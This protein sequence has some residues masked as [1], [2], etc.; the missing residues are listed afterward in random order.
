MA[1]NPEAERTASKAG[2]R[3]RSAAWFGAGG[4]LGF[5]HRSW[6]KGEGLPDDVFDGRPV[7]GIANSWSELTPC[8]I[9]LRRLAEA[10][11][12]GVW[13]A[14]G[15]P[16]EFPTISLG[17][18]LMRP[19]TM[20]FRNLMAMDVEESIRANP[21]D[22]VVL[23]ASCD[24]TVPGQLMGAA[25]VDLPTIMVT[26]GP[27]LSGNFQG[28][29]IGSGTHVWKYSE[30]VRAGEMT[31]EE[32]LAAEICMS[33]SDGHCMTMGTAS[34]LASMSEALGIQ[35]AG[36]AAV[37]AV[38]ARRTVFAHQAGRRIV[39]MVEEDLRPSH[40]LTREAFENAIRVNAAIGGSTNFVVHLLALAGRV[41]VPL[42][43]EDFDDLAKDIP[44]LVN[45]MPSGTYL[46]EDFFHAGG[47]PALMKELGDLLH[48]D[49]RTVTGRTVTENVA[50]AR[51]WNRE[52][53]ATLDEPIQPSGSGTAV[54]RGNL[55]P[56]G[57]IIKQSA[58]SQ[59][60]MKHRGPAVV[61]DSI[62]EYETWAEDADLDVDE[63][64]VIVVRNAGPKGYPGMP[65]I[66]NVALPR[67][68]LAQGITD[69]VRISDARMSGTSYGTVVLHVAPEAAAGGPL[70]LVRTGD[71][72]ELD[73]PA[74][75]LRIDVSDEELSRRREAWRP[76]PPSADRGYVRLYLDHVMQADRGADLDFLTGGSGDAVPRRPF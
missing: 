33:R 6:V 36:S 2:T 75:S 53:I 57:A 71:R 62:E 41:G 30:A 24:K 60:L 61:F 66:A 1:G 34:T 4:K 18:T 37:P 39:G 67:K 7:I 19:S 51:C 25:S 44:L 48:G 63:D 72:I 76:P 26:G 11:K 15:L 29:S 73:V 64:S 28:E 9:H 49:A 14:G 50:D 3:R 8:N 68:V 40:I 23:L 27:K 17:E 52:V 16:F 20:L 43:L 35:L 47:L 10:V 13:E 55:A 21:L 54:L 38:D 12:R 65:E 56:D 42:S 70:A 32:F 22:G 31:Q 45:L 5:I 69:M 46:M 58:A 59:E 74:R